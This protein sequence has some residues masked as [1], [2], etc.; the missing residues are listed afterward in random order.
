MR[1][2][3]EVMEKYEELMK[4]YPNDMDMVQDRIICYM[5]DVRYKSSE[6]NIIEVPLE[7]LN[8]Y[9]YD[10]ED[11]YLFS[12]LNDTISIVLNSL[13]YREKYILYHRFYLKMTLDQIA[14][15]LNVSRGRIRQIEA[16]ALRKSRYPSRIRKLIDFMSDIDSEIFPNACNDI[17]DMIDIDIDKDLVMKLLNREIDVR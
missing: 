1:T 15:M 2:E 7:E 3:K 4:E 11:V 5:E 14:F 8:N 6:N 17:R 10:M 9:I 16:K 12:T 13:L